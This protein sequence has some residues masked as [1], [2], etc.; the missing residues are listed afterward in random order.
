MNQLLQIVSARPV[1]ITL[2]KSTCEYTRAVIRP[3]TIK[4]ALVYQAEFFTKTQ[5]FHENID[6]DGLFTRLCE[7]FPKSFLQLDAACEDGTFSLGM[8]KKGKLLFNSKASASVSKPLEHNRQ[9]NYILPEGTPIPALVDLGVMTPDGRVVKARFDKFKQINRFT[10]LVSDLLKN[11]KKTS[12]SVIDFG[13]GKSYLTF[14]LYY[15]LTQIKNFDA[16]IVGL[17]LKEKVIA[18][19]NEIAKKYGYDGLSFKV[20]DIAGFPHDVPCDM[21]ITLHACDTATDFALFNAIKRGAKYIMS[22]PCCQH[23]LNLSIKECEIPLMTDYGILKERF[24]ALATDALRA[25]LLT[26]CGYETQV[27]EFIDIAHSPKNLLI[28]A[29]KKNL[30]PQTRA[31]ALEK[32][33]ELLAMLNTSQT[34]FDLIKKEGL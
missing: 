16:K 10:E 25:A 31:A 30:S 14:I 13:C 15:Y 6:K 2:S 23:E 22:V 34:L 33:K 8:T 4:G 32:A 27:L 3:A 12:I 1:R 7:L 21:V 29:T 5:A 26:Y 24:C 19:C 28:R 20:G 18:D 11:E 17:D 9:K